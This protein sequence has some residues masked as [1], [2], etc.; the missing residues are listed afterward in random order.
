M[1]PLRPLA[2]LDASSYVLEAPGEGDDEDEV[3][4][5]SP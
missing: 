5:Y 3:T 1:W 2:A 4:G